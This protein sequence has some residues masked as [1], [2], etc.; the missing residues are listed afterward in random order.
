MTR[1]IVNL[2]AFDLVWLA[3]VWGAGSGRAWVGPLAL[4]AALAV[5]LWLSPNRRA[6]GQ[7]LA[8]TAAVGFIVES[9]NGLAG[10]LTYSEAWPGLGLA[11]MAP[12]W[13]VAM[14]VNFGTVLGTSLRWMAGKPVLAALFGAISGPLAYYFGAK[15]GGVAT[16][17]NATLS[18][19]VIAAIY[20]VATPALLWVAVR[21]APPP[22]ER[23][24]EPP[25]S[26]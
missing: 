22:S 18:Y 16:G 3:C 6:E 13:L 15:F 23:T 10:I 17:E 2:V 5:H 24:P 9:A 1:I 21:L 19:G 20:G 11:W 25:A 26:E 8:I 4:V 12:L 14:W 7:F